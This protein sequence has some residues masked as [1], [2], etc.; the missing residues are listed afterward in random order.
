MKYVFRKKRY[1]LLVGLL[2]AM[3][4]VLVRV[5]R[6][7]KP[8][9]DRNFKN[10]L[11]VR[12]DHL[13]DVLLATGVPKLLKENFPGACVTFLTSSWAAPLLE[14][15]PFIDEVL[16]FD[17]P[18]FRRKGAAKR[19]SALRLPALIRTVRGKRFDLGLGLRGDLRENFILWLSGIRER[20]GYGIT[21]GGFFMTKEVP[22]RARMHER[23]RAANLLRP[24]GVRAD[25][26]KSGLYPSAEEITNARHILDAVGL[27]TGMKLVGFQWGA[28]TVS[29]DWPAG[30]VHDFL[31]RFGKKFPDFKI[32][33]VGGALTEDGRAV[34]SLPNCVNLLGKTTL[35]EL[36]ALMS[37]FLFFIGPDSGPTH[38]ASALGVPTL[39]LFSG[40]NR[41]EEW[42]PLAENASVIRHQVQCSPCGLKVCNVPGHPCMA[43][44]LPEEVIQLLE[45][46]LE[47]PDRVP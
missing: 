7:R 2:D 23:D 1:V 13:G 6:R 32:V 20:I 33:L 30:R 27:E 16:I 21:G 12:M 24:L 39:F 31:E 10:I 38:I 45:E 43:G 44:I 36:C 17:A 15:N 25:S 8:L 14:G 35:R 4:Y 22:Y 5:F 28:G 41:F 42:R 40:T 29:K 3:G 26:L 9:L 19:T 18:W 47:S 34:S 37:H 46:R 11:I